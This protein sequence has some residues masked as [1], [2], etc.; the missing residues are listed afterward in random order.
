MLFTLYP[1]SGQLYFGIKILDIFLSISLIFGTFVASDNKKTLS[2]SILLGAV[3]ILTKTATYWTGNI[4]L[5][6]MTLGFYAAFFVFTTA[7]ILFHIAKEERVTSDI[8]M[9]AISVYLLI[10]V[11]W[12]LLYM[13]LVTIQPDSFAYVASSSID[14]SSSSLQTKPSLIV[15]YSFTTLTT[16][17]YGDII[18][19]KPFTRMMSSVEA[20]TGQLYLAILIGKLIGMHISQKKS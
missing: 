3:A 9:G 1:L 14:N 10:G 20:I 13:G 12:S 18:P 2:I 8:I 7:I 17:G 11:I 19:V 5:S 6:F 15:Y 16:L 4:F